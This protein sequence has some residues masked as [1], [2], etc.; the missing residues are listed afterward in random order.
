VLAV[1][2]AAPSSHLVDA[3]TRTVGRVEELVRTVSREGRDVDYYVYLATRA[4][5]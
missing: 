2:S 4:T 3:L 5:P 1:W